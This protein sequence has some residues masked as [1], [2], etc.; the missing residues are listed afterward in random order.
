MLLSDHVNG[1]QGAGIPPFSKRIFPENA[2]RSP[3]EIEGAT[4]TKIMDEKCI[5]ECL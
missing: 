1:L 4:A 3:T 2:N 5:H